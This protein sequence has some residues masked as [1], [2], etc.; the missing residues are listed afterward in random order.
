MDARAGHLA[1]CVHR[2]TCLLDAVVAEQDG[3]ARLAQGGGG[4]AAFLG[5][6]RLDRQLQVDRIGAAARGRGAVDAVAGGG[7]GLG[8]AHTLMVD[9]QTLSGVNQGRLR[10]I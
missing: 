10:G 7:N 3:H 8:N 9:G 2:R 5:R 6:A 4:F 1:D